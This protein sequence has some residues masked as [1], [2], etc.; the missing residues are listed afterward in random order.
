MSRERP[1]ASEVPLFAD[2][3]R[4]AIVRTRWNAEIVGELTR[5]CDARLREL[6]AAVD[7]HQVPGAFEL[8]TACKWL[9]GVGDFAAVVA[10]GCVIRG[11]TP[12]FDFVAGEC[13]R[14]LNDVGLT[15]GVPCIFGVLTVNTRQQALDRAGGE[16]GHAGVA[17]A[18]AAAEMAALRRELLPVGGRDAKARLIEIDREM[19]AQLRREDAARRSGGGGPVPV[20]ADE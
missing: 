20:D 1:E 15:T 14:G 12:H 5:G 7:V 10:I 13:A 6:G 3:D 19:A 18:E 11:D 2:G 17:A 4:V 9:A 16:H 8:P